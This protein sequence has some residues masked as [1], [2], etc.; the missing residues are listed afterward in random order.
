MKVFIG[1]KGDRSKHVALKLRHW[2]PKVLQKVKPWISDE[3]IYSGARWRAALSKELEDTDFGIIVLT[4]E[5]QR[6]PWINFEAGALSKK[7]DESAVIPYLV[8]ISEPTEVTGPLEDFQ[9]KKATEDETLA[10]LRDIN[11]RLSD[12]ALDDGQLTETFKLFWPEFNNTL[13]TLPTAVGHHEQRSERELLEEILER[14][15]SLGRQSSDKTDYPPTPVGSF[16]RLMEDARGLRL[17]G[18]QIWEPPGGVTQALGVQ[19]VTT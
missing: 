18:R 9:M 11:R 10:L 5:N 19:S 6:E 13:K 7:L 4:Q 8:D 16:A 15:R 17:L 14:V 3:D 1:W 2:L 12:E